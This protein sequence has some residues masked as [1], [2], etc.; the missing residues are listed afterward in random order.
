MI[1]DIVVVTDAEG[2][3][4]E[5][6]AFPLATE[7][8][9]EL[10]GLCVVPEPP[11]LDFARAELRYDLIMADLQDDIETAKAAALAFE[12][13]AKAWNVPASAAVICKE[14]PQGESTLVDII[15]VSDLIIVAQPNPDAPRPTD[16]QV[17]TLLLKSG[18]PCLVV[19]YVSQHKLTLGTVT[20]AWDGSI[21]AARALADAMPLLRRASRVE[22]VQVVRSAFPEAANLAARLTRHLKRHGIASTFQPIITSLPVAEVLLSHIADS[23]SDLLVMGAYG[24]SQL[25]EAFLGGASRGILDAM[26][27]PVLMSH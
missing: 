12:Q 15:R 9:A 20:I 11:F 16:Y 2:D 3:G 26:T 27:V 1:K 7:F 14:D 17:E 10:T 21:P 13:R 4:I 5:T 24:H 19:P 23:G 6:L 25:R 8:G 22:A 18:R